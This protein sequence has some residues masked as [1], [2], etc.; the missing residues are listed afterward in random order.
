MR[1]YNELKRTALAT[2]EGGGW[3]NPPAWAVLVRMYPIRAA[4]SYL[5]RLHRWG[6]L[7]RRRDARG[8]LLYRLSQRGEQRLAWLRCGRNAPGR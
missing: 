7:E 4:Y 8:L 6:L 1:R 2:F 5:L 3:L